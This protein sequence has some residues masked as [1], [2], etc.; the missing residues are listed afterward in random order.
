ME[1][2]VRSDE[3]RSREKTL[4]LLCN[5]VEIRKTD[6]SKLKNVP[7]SKFDSNKRTEKL[8]NLRNLLEKFFYGYVTYR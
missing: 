3:V 2:E 5:M 1:R 7:I 6:M 8:K 4:K